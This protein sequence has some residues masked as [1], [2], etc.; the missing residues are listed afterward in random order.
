M[1]ENLF[2]FP[3]IKIDGNNE[4]KKLE[5]KQRFGNL[6]SGED[7]DYDIVYAWA[8]YPYW[9]LIGLEDSWLPTTES[10]EKAMGNPPK[11]DACIVRFVNVGQLLV[12]MTRKKF[13]ES[14]G[15]FAN[16]F[17]ANKAKSDSSKPIVNIRTLSIDEAKKI[18]GEDL[19][20]RM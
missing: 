14:I 19:E 7:D 9:D 10:L 13:K 20:D 15:E 3:V 2:K 4:D 12:P 16:K 6:S 8:E 1:L 5:K 11:F 17:E 18:F